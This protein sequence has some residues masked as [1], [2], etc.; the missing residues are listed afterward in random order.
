M[1]SIPQFYLIDTPGFDDT[2]KTDTQVLRE[3]TNWLS[4]AYT[5]DLKLTG[6]IYLHRILDVK[7]GGSAM[8]NLRMFK[9]L[10]GD[11]SLGSVVLAT[12]FWGMTNP[13]IEQSRE[14]Q[15]TTRSDFWGHFIQK[16]SRVF[17]QDQGKESATK[18]IDYL[19]GRRRPVVLEIQR[20]MNEQN[21]TLDQTGAGVEVQG[22]L[23]K[24][25]AA[26]EEE[27]AAVRADMQRALA[28]KDSEWQEELAAAKKE[29][30][31]KLR[32]DDESRTQLHINRE[33]LRQE[34]EREREE[35]RRQHLEAMLE[36]QRNVMQLQHDLELARRDNQ[37]QLAAQELRWKL[38]IEQERVATER[39]K[40]EASSCTVM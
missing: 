22:D 34:E 32:K 40:A 11:D 25:K 27:M 2:H 23:A 39:A 30:E 4:T 6:I 33:N 12:T 13:E 38:Q 5:A 9:K 17:R 28:Q 1:P 31:E 10:C 7:M 14:A 35:E 36:Y 18:I 29:I 26:H 21:K 16:G 15:L 8:K 3:I 19:V 20:E 24:A 37:H